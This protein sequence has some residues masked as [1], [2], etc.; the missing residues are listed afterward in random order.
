MTAMD[1][2]EIISIIIPCNGRP[3]LRD[4]LR[5][6]RDSETDS[7]YEVI[8]VGSL[9][10][11]YPPLT[12]PVR[13]QPCTGLGTGAM[14]NL[15]AKQAQGD[16]LLFTD[17][18]CVVDPDWIERA[19]VATTPD[20][21]V[22]AGGLR[23]PESNPLD[24]GDNLAI[25]HAVHVTHSIGP[26]R[27]S[28]GTNNLAVRR[29]VFDRLG[30]FDEDLTVGEDSEFLDRVRSAGYPVW[31]DPSF[32]VRHQS[33]RNTAAQVRAHARWYAEGYCHLMTSGYLPS[34]FW[35][36]EQRFGRIK[37]CAML[38]SAIKATLGV[39]RVVLPHPPFWHYIRAW[40]TVW[41][42]YYTRRLELF[43]CLRETKKN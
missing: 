24:L 27:G 25:F 11:G 34:S 39:I 43:R 5:S 9:P 1:K 28:V 38:W 4:A 31:F 26:A 20:H 37:G 13:L 10:E 2:H 6:I 42:F 17:S 36:A 18:D 33:N 22:V 3:C 16:L 23:F 19:A 7:P 41:L 14:R 35:R 40:P 30:G 29:D 12:G 32:S 21:P 8:V 15:A